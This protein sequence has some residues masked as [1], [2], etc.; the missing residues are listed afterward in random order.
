LTL[1]D[2]NLKGPNPVVERLAELVDAEFFKMQQNEGVETTRQIA[3]ANCPT[4][5]GMGARKPAACEGTEGL[6]H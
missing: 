5:N 3:Y 4:R 2:G 1:A 6:A